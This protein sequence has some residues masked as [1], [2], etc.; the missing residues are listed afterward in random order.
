[1]STDT[2]TCIKSCIIDDVVE[3]CVGEITLPATQIIYQYH[4]QVEW[5]PEESRVV[6]SLALWVVSGMVLMCHD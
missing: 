2:Y 6:I 4:H 1:M 3:P 5:V